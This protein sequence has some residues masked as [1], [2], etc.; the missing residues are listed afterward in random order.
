M[1][2]A[3]AAEAGAATMQ[4]FRQAM[5]LPSPWLVGAALLAG[6]AAAGH[7]VAGS[8]VGA[9]AT[10]GP[11][12]LGDLAKAELFFASLQAYEGHAAAFIRRCLWCL[13]CFEVPGFA[14]RSWKHGRCGGVRPPT[15]I[16]PA[17]VDAASSRHPIQMDGVGRLAHAAFTGL[18]GREA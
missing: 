12:G 7:G 2:A 4:P 13:K 9:G 5:P 6:D 11:D 16:P 17:L 8:A 15:A 18:G 1:Q 10:R 14:H 3:S